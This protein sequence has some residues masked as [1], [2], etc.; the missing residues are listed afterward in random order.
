MAIANALAFLLYMGSSVILIRRF[1]QKD[2]NAVKTSIPVGIMIIMALLFHAVDIFFTMKYAGGWH[3]GLFTTFSLTTWLM[4]L[5]AFVIGAKLPQSHPGIIVYPLVAL[6]LILKVELPSPEPP[7]LSD[8]ALEWHVLLSLAAYSLFM[9]AAIQAIILAIQEK[10]LRRKHAAGLMRK[11]PP[12]QS[13]ESGLFQLIITGFVLLTLG[14]VT[15]L[16]FVDDLFAQHL[17]HKTIL[18]FVSWCVFAALL[19]GRFRYGWR[20]KTAVKWTLVG[21]SFLVLAYM[22]SKFVLEYLLN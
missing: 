17:V 1:V 5:I 16:M 11:L 2:Q 20:G 10:Q 14:L 4:A 3:L 9:L 8:P 15:G 19:W 22:G 12:L 7:S 13:M 21:F 18:S 6:S